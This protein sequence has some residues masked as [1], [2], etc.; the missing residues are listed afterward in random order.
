MHRP[1]VASPGG[2][3]VRSVP[4]PPA[5]AL[6]SDSRDFNETDTEARV[7]LVPPSF[8]IGRPRSRVFGVTQARALDI[9]YIYNCFIGA[10]PLLRT[11]TIHGY[12][13]KFYDNGVVMVGTA[14]DRFTMKVPADE[15]SWVATRLRAELIERQL[16]AADELPIDE[17]GEA[18][19]AAKVAAKVCAADAKAASRKISAA[20]AAREQAA[21]ALDGANHNVTRAE[22]KRDLAELKLKSATLQAKAAKLA[23]LV[24]QLAQQ[25]PKAAPLQAKLDAFLAPATAARAESL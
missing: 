9:I 14:G 19:M 6:R 4:V 22:H 21:A 7:G 2:G 3:A 23:P 8:C 10:M 25:T 16:A 5:L 20:A 1:R 15:T 13:C 18:A 17:A 12:V 11:E 24:S